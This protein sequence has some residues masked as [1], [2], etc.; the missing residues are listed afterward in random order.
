MWGAFLSPNVFAYALINVKGTIHVHSPYFSVVECFSSSRPLLHHSKPVLSSD[1]LCSVFPT[2]TS[3]LHN[4][5]GSWRVKKHRKTQILAKNSLFPKQGLD[6]CLKRGASPL[7]ILPRAWEDDRQLAESALRHILF[8]SFPVTL[9]IFIHVHSPPES[10]L[11][12]KWICYEPVLSLRE[13]SMSCCC[14]CGSRY[15]ISHPPPRS[16]HP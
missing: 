3:L 8:D 12:L 10:L 7:F 15:V 13:T 16:A 5:C 14:C 9:V 2:D 6:C 11:L 4:F 1:T